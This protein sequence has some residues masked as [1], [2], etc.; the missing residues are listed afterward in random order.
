MKTTRVLLCDMKSGSFLQSPDGWTRKAE[1]AHDFGYIAAAI[2]FAR[3][4]ELSA[5]ELVVAF[6]Q[7]E[8]KLR[9]PIAA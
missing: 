4:W 7:P 5:I 2:S 8:Y 6:E 1:N 3:D 9:V